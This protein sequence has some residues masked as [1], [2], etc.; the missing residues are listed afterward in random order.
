MARCGLTAPS[1]G[2]SSLRR[3]IERSP[4]REIAQ[5]ALHRLADIRL[6]RSGGKLKLGGDGGQ[7]DVAK[8]PRQQPALT[9]RDF[10]DVG[11]GGEIVTHGE[12]SATRAAARAA[13]DTDK[14]KEIG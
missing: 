1:A 5:A 8:Q 13:A 3:E 9:G 7:A 4:G 2:A 6:K 12:H 14:V 10:D 11:D